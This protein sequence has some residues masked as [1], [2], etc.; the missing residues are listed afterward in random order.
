MKLLGWS[1]IKFYRYPYKEEI[2]HKKETPKVYVHTEKIS[3][4]N[5]VRKWPFSS[6]GNMY[7]KKLNLLHLDFG[8]L[9]SRTVR[10]KK[11]KHIKIFLLFRPLNVWYF[12]MAAKAD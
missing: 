1:L 11:K 6:Q 5:S 4:E 3:Y 7:Q 12:L 2:G 8:P 10:R 9:A